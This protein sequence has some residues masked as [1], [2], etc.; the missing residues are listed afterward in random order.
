MAKLSCRWEVWK[1]Y[2]T[3]TF[4]IISTHYDGDHSLHKELKQLL[5]CT[6]KQ[7]KLSLEWDVIGKSEMYFI[8]LDDLCWGDPYEIAC[9]LC[10]CDG[11]R[12]FLLYKACTMCTQPWMSNSLSFDDG[13]CNGSCN[14]RIHN[15]NS[16]LAA[17]NTFADI[18][19]DFQPQ[20][21]KNIFCQR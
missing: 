14:N 19:L 2:Y 5:Y 9:P 20:H 13:K 4:S 18:S 10:L 15:D 16:I 12:F 8:W 21:T 7:N 3:I 17:G 11:A 1:K 6:T